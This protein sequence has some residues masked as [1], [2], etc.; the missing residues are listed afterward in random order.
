MIKTIKPQ[1]FAV[2]IEDMVHTKKMTSFAPRAQWMEVP[3]KNNFT[4]VALCLIDC[5]LLL[6]ISYETCCTWNY[7]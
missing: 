4:T 6:G 5:L 2:I 7:L 3:L 1:D